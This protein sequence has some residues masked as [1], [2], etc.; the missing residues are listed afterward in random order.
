MLKHIMYDLK[1]VILLSLK[2]YSNVLVDLKILKQTYDYNCMREIIH[3]M[4]YLFCV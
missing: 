4:Q 3:D 1:F 2:L